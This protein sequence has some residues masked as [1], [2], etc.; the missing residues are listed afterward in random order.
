MGDHSMQVT[1]PSD[2]EV[3]MS[4]V[5]DAP[6]DLVF[7]AHTSCEHM[8]HWW[9]P[10]RYVISECDI[11]FRPGGAY[12]IVQ[13]GAEGDEYAFRGEFREIDRPSRIVWTFEWEGM[14]GHISV[15]TVT[16]DEQDGKTTL[17][18]TAV[19]DSVEDRDG[20]LASGMTEGA[21]ETW[22]RLAEYVQTLGAKAGR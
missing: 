3:V 7:E 8:S 17:T 22:D 16:F 21:A 10:R 14:P 5:F 19:Y 4:R 18:A 20:T 11:D 1:T 12:R 15:Q 13:R 6:R 9:G 2:R